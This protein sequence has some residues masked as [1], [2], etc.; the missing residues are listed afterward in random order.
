MLLEFMTLLVEACESLLA[1]LSKWQVKAAQSE[2]KEL[3]ALRVR[4][5]NHQMKVQEDLNQ[6]DN[7]IDVL[8]YF[9]DQ[10]YKEL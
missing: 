6:V 5:K 1:F 10:E 3:K 7:E 9:L 8:Q 2:L 4:I